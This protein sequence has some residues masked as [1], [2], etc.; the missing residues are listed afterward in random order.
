MADPAP[1]PFS[2]K[3]F[4][5]IFWFISCLR[6]FQDMHMHPADHYVARTR[7]LLGPAFAFWIALLAVIAVWL[8]G[9]GV[10]PNLVGHGIENFSDVGY[11]L[12]LVL[13]ITGFY[14]FFIRETDY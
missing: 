2:V 3:L 14:Q 13:Y 4:Q 7:P 6:S 1:Q 9:N 8:L 12:V 11:L 5:S 10:L